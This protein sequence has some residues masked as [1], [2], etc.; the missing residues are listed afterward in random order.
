M[1]SRT[2]EYFQGHISGQWRAYNE[3]L[4]HL[5]TL[6]ENLVNKKEIYKYIINL[7]PKKMDST[8]YFRVKDGGYSW[9][10]PAHLVAKNRAEYYA[11]NDSDTTYEDEFAFTIDDD[12]ELKDWFLNNMDW[13]DVSKNARLE[14]QPFKIFPD[15]SEAEIE[16]HW[17]DV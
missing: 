10:F 13:K 6:E 9:I 3:I 14:E 15:L 8:K 1:G 16:L 11:K 2:E 5:N 4:G 12:Y 7:R 17:R